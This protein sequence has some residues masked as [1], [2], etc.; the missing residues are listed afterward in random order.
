M[1]GFCITTSNIPQ[2]GT[3]YHAKLIS[4][5]LPNKRFE[6]KSLVAFEVY[7]SCA[8]CREVLGSL[9]VNQIPSIFVSFA[10]CELWFKIMAH[11]LMIL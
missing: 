1:S 3:T 10:L 6:I 9:S 4:A 2:L 7:I 5:S 11:F 8:F